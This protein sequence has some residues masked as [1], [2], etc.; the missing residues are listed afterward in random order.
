MS[1]TPNDVPFV[2]V[3]KFLECRKQSDKQCQ[4]DFDSFLEV[5]RYVKINMRKRN[6]YDNLGLNSSSEVECN[7]I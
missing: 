5:L 1:Q 4:L 2:S 7:A 3:I 6:R